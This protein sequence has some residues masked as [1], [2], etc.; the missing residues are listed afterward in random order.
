MKTTNCLRFLKKSWDLGC[1]RLIHKCQ[2]H[3][4]ENIGEVLSNKRV[5]IDFPE[6]PHGA[7][8]WIVE[9]E[10]LQC[11]EKSLFDAVMMWSRRECSRC[12]LPVTPQNMRSVLG[13]IIYQIRFPTMTTQEFA[14]CNKM[15]PELLSADEMTKI[16]VFSTVPAAKVRFNVNPRL[17]AT[18][19]SLYAD[20]GVQEVA[21]IR[22]ITKGQY[23]FLIWS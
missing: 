14:E 18:F 11:D 22:R 23:D 16:M 8:K 19:T 9:L 20:N 21:T 10:T 17:E 15:Y 1:L 12:K 7:V 2:E 6:L 4:A 5:P 3:L 13:D